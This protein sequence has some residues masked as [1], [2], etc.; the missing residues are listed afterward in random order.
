MKLVAQNKKAYHDYTIN[1]TL[2]C[3]I[4]LKGTEVKS[5]RQTKLSLKE[6][7][8]NIENGQL[9]IKQMHISPYEQ[10]GQFNADPLRDRVLLAHKKEIRWLLEA[11]QVKGKTL[12]PIKAYF[13]KGNLKI[14]IAI[15]TGKQNH[16]K[17]NALK[18]RDVQRQL[19]RGDY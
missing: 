17:R 6:A 11:K 7:W 12:I 2:E 19:Q 18:E 14:V 9:V 10:G 16:D 13:D 15:A 3:G 5:C 1:E 8:V 4:V